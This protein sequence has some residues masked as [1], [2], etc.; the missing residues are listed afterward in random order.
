[1]DLGERREM[2]GTGGVGAQR[3][4][5]PEA[6]SVEVGRSLSSGHKFSF[7]DEE[8]GKKTKERDKGDRSGG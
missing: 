6:I 4:L 1:L 5:E 8:L 7:G 3:G 2:R